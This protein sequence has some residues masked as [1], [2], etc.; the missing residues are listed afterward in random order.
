MRQLQKEWMHSYSN[1]EPTLCE[2]CHI[3]LC[4]CVVLAELGDHNVFIYLFILILF[5]ND[6]LDL[7]LV[8]GWHLW[9]EGGAKLWGKL[10]WSR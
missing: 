6:L 3:I 4:V 1:W 5:F 9:G 8:L 7:F 2:L 10:L